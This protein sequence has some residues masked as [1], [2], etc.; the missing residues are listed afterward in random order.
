VPR[1]KRSEYAVEVD[2]A[3]R[4]AVEGREAR[5]F[6]DEWT[7]EHLVLA[8]LATCVVASFRHHADREGLTATATA[9]ATGAVFERPDGRWGFVELRCSVGATLDP[10]P[11]D[12]AL[13]PLLERAERGCFVGS[14]L[15][16][17]PVYSWTINGA[18]VG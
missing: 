6:G 14:S 7:P 12:D 9:S 18:Q 3:G 4:A 15:D 17:T 2:E 16:P 13:Q 5:T 1:R 11:G 10:A 8:A